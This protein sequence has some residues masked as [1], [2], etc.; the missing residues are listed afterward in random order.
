M[1]G[2][3]NNLYKSA[4][5]YNDQQQYNGIIDAEMVS[6]TEGGTGNITM[7]QIHYVTVKILVQGNH[8]ISFGS[9]VFQT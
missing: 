6:T 8:S 1:S 5:R 7:S 9:I 3:T 2:K 4:V